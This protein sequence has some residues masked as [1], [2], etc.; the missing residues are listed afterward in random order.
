M[1]EYL[2]RNLI[3]IP[4]LSFLMI[5]ES[6][7]SELNDYL[8][9]HVGMIEVYITNKSLTKLCFLVIFS[10]TKYS[11]LKMSLPFYDLQV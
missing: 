11:L 6:L 7:K 2:W 9:H 10:E 5:L 1:L 8:V 3:S 4:F